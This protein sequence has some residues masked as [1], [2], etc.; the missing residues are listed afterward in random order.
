MP[1]KILA[2][3]TSTEACSV[4]L[5]CNDQFVDGFEIAPRRHNALILPMLE[6]VLAESGIALT[7]LD[8]L[9][10]G[11]G[12]GSF[13][14]VRIA[15]SVVQGIAFAVDLPVIPVSTLRALAQG[16]YRKWGAQYVLSSIDAYVKEIYWGVYQLNQNKIMTAVT[17]DSVCAPAYIVFDHM[18]KNWVGV[19]SGW[20]NYTEILQEKIG[21]RLQQ[22]HAHRYPNARDIAALAVVD[23]QQN[24]AVS[25]EHALPVYLSDISFCKS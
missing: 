5:F 22:W 25:A 24:K 10:F 14:G 2:L 13:T 15:A 18:E 4:S 17:A 20:N 19:G 8:A 21:G 23:Y 7:Q 12:P 9:A 3:D 1:L 6:T 16:A 11:C